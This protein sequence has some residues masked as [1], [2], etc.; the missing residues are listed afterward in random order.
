MKKGGARKGAKSKTVVESEDE[1]EKGDKG[2]V[3]GGEGVGA[4]AGENAGP[5]KVASPPAKKTKKDYDREFS[6]QVF[7]NFRAWAMSSNC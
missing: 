7:G 4:A 3:A 2:A 1:G 6:F 5:S